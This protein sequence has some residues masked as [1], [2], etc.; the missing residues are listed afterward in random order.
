MSDPTEP[1]IPDAPN[2]PPVPEVFSEPVHAQEP[3][4][5]LTPPGASAPPPV[6]T[7]PSPPSAPQYPGPPPGSAGPPLAQPYPGAPPLAYGTA[8]AA[9]PAPPSTG[10]DSRP[11]TLAVVALIL[12]G[13]GAAMAFIPFV[14]WVSG[15]VLLAAFIIA[16]VALVSKK[17]GG[18]G[19]SIAALV[20]S[21]VGWIVSIV[22][23]VASFALIANAARDS[24]TDDTGAV[25]TE[26]PVEEEDGPA[27]EPVDARQ[28][29]VVVEST[30]GRTSYDPT[31]WW[32]V[33]VLENPNT[34]YIFDF[35][36]VDVEAIDANGTILDTASD[37]RTILSG[38]TAVTGTFF[39]IGQ[40]EVASLNARGPVATAAVR[41]PADETGAFTL[42]GLSAT[43]DSFSTSVTGTVSGSFESEQEL[44]DVV[45]IARA[46]DGQ[47]LGAESTYIDRLPAGGGKVQFEAR[48][49][50][51]LPAGTT[52]EAFAA[53]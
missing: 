21:V 43:T 19:L 12:A 24:I 8:P 6:P 13:A 45:V 2:Q 35:A 53:L 39:S 23:A 48:F 26:A 1:S 52:F 40:G 17:Q 15:A 22:V 38:R 27:Q 42:E 44:V 10:G 4:S 31:T 11:K 41:S 30:F 51:E 47:I 33:V 46:P 37:Y 18:K 34:D 28:D 36:G 49:L 29:L 3:V 7:Y 50:T 32:Y 25:A 5:G 14:T 16:I 9:V 20:L